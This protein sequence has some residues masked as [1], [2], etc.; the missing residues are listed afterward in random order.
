MSDP[1]TVPE[2]EARVVRLFH[3]ALPPEQVRFL[4]DEP[5]AMADVLGLTSLDTE[6]ADLIKI[7]DLDE[8]GLAT[9]L[10]DGAGVPEAEVAP[11]RDRLA[12][13]EGWVLVVLSRAFGGKAAQIRPAKGVNLVATYGQSPTDWT[14]RPLETESARRRTP[15][16]REVRAR[17]RRIGGVIFAVIMVLVALVIYLLT[18]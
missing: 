10:T 1:L 8:L 15:P 6:H 14:A 4:R 16:P 11:D 18:R 3:L 9:Y 5:G 13:L 2:G 7:A 12:A 17:S